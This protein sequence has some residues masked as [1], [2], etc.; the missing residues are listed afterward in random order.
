MTVPSYATETDVFEK[1]GFPKQAVE[2]ITGLNAKEVTDLVNGFLRKGEKSVKDALEIPHVVPHE[3]HIGT[4]EDDEFDLG[5]DDEAFYVDYDP[6]G[7]LIAIKHCY[8]G[9]YRMRKPYPKDCDLTDDKDLWDATGYVQPAND[10]TNR[11]AGDYAMT[12][13]FTLGNLKARYPDVTNDKYID[14]NIDIFDYMFF[15]VRSNTAGIVVTIRL[16]DADDNYNT[17]TY[18]ISKKG[19]W[20]RV[21]LHLD[22]NFTPVIDWDDNPLFYFEIEVSGACILNVDNLCFNDEWAFTAPSG[23]LVIMRK[24]TNEPPYYGRAFY[25][26]YTYDPFKVVVP[27]NIK[28]ATA[29]LAAI[30]LID[31]LIGVREGAVAFEFEAESMIPLPD[32]ETLY[33][34]KG[35]LLAR[36][37]ENL[38]GYGYGWSGTVAR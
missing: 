19:H 4:G 1:S 9:R 22:D 24:S 20:Y 28:T 10:A 23:K 17:A 35:S 26:T 6:I 21:M 34:R 32:K 12:Y 11:Q 8:F 30:E 27:E 15:R 38:R 33:A 13:T 14:K 36:A 29:Q 31:H 16:Y 3:L 2:R 7:C 25:V 5:P 18:T 37:K